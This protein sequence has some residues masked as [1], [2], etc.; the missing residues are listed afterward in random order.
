MTHYH[1]QKNDEGQSILLKSPTK[2]TEA[3]TWTSPTEMATFTPGGPVPGELNGIPFASW[4]AAPSTNDDWAKVDGQHHGL[5]DEP[6]FKPKSGKRIAAGVV[7]EET[8]GRVWVIHP[9]NAFGGYEATFPKGTVGNELPLQA[10]AIREAYEESGLQVA[11][12]GFFADSERSQS[13]TRYYFA[14]RV[15]GTPSDMGWESQGASLVPLD[16]LGGILTHKN[17]GPLVQALQQEKRPARRHIIKYEFGLTSGQRILSTINGFRRRTG[18]WPTRLLIDRGTANAI[19]DEILTPLGWKML[20]SKLKIELIEAGT[21][22]AEKDGNRFEYDAD[23]TV[24]PDNE[25]ADVWIWNNKIM[26][27]NSPR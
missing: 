12:T 5:F 11:I 15:G 13:K 4:T 1:P 7:I 23:H 22:F 3:S 2:A 21:L 26:G 10:T 27:N 8:D 25:R 14:R 24:P 16:L 18:E 9:S 20:E 17:D 19:K 6:I